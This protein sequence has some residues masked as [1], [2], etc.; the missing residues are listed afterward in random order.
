M[1]IPRRA[2]MLLASALLL[3]LPAVAGPVL[4]RIEETGT[5]RLGFRTDAPP[6]AALAAGRP[7]GFSIDLC[8]RV[9][10]A[11]RE[12]GGL[13]RLTARFEP[14]G[15]GQR[16]EAL[17]AGEIDVLCGATTATLSR[18]E[19]VSFSLPIFLTGVA[20]V[21]RA[22]APE[23]AREVLLEA[24]PAAFSETVV[25]TA[26]SG[27]RFGVRRDTTAEAWLAGTAPVA[28][29]LAEVEPFATHE[30]G[31]EAVRAGEIDAY[32]ADR[33]I[34]A[35]QLRAET[36]SDGLAVSEKTFTHEPYALALPRG[37]ED[38]RL[39][40]DRALSRLY[41]TGEV[42]ALFERHFGAPP[43]EVRAF[44]RRTALPE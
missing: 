44:Y 3:S 28:D 30:A 8:A 6:F 27:M 10:E 36:G 35:G 37:D 41:R 19:T 22:D 25:R 33:A 31:I 21:M 38:F 5:L 14:V 11:V 24:S 42:T 15:T 29:G 26:L 2:V 17:V 23:L 40:I 12:T 39:V 18:R 43:A 7:E 9:A 34:L 1:P 16:F 20:A 4:E 13:E 32:F